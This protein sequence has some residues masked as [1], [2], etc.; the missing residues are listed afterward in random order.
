MFCRIV[1]YLVDVSVVFA[2]T[3]Q[4]GDNRVDKEEEDEAEDDDLLHVDV[5]LRGGDHQGWLCSQRLFSV[6]TL[7]SGGGGVTVSTGGGGGD[8]GGD[9]G[10]HF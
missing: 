8:G 2:P 7:Y 10:G 5:E 6:C 4:E 3:V 9:G 1:R